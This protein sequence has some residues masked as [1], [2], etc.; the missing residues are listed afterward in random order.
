MCVKEGG[1]CRVEAAML[2]PPL[3]A[4]DCV[5]EKEARWYGSTSL[6]W[7]MECRGLDGFSL[8]I[9]LALSSHRAVGGECVFGL[10]HTGTALHSY[11]SR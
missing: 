10:K 8:V 11:M 2:V 9:L 3:R 6:A 5:R 7:L 1:G 4:P